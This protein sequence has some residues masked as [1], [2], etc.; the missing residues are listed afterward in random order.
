MEF[1]NL[2]PHLLKEQ[3]KDRTPTGAFGT[4]DAPEARN[5][6]KIS[7]IRAKRARGEKLTEKEKSYNF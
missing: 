6:P 4:D 2:Y 3:D 5:K 7:D 1:Q